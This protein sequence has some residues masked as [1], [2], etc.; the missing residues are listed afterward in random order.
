MKK[1]IIAALVILVSSCSC[2]SSL[3]KELQAYKEYY[4]ATEN[5]LDTL[6]S[7]YNWVDAFDPY[8]YYEAVSNLPR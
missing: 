5:L 7:H 6:E 2:T 4:E 8:D 1:I 3:K